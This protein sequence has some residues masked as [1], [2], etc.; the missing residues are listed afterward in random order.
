MEVKSNSA[1]RN[2]PDGERML[3]APYVFTD[4]KTTIAQLKE[5]E[6][7]TKNDRNGI[8]IF[9]TEGLTIVLV[10]LHA[11]ARIDVNNT[12]GIVAIQ[13]LQGKIK[14][15]TEN[16]IIEIPADAQQIITFHTDFNHDVEALEESA[17]LLTVSS[18]IR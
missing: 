10:A 13:V 16:E 8:T 17:V 11:S 3:D 15:S 4:I 18:E 14:L 12:E 7:W 9:K 2:R 1:T 6:S 5:E